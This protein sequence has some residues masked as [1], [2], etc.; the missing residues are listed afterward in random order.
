[1]GR[2]ALKLLAILAL[3]TV[4]WLI[5]WH[6]LAADERKTEEVTIYRDDFGIPNIF[7]ASEEGVAYG[8]GYA[9]A[10]D[11]L[12]EIFKQYRRAEGTMA[13]AFG[14]SFLHDD[15][16][17][18]LW[19]H[20]AVAEANYPKLSARSRVLIEAYQ[21]GIKQYM[22]E[23]PEEVPAWAPKL[24]PWQI[25]ALGRF[26]IWGWPEGD[27]SGDLQRAG[28]QPDPIAAR[29]SNQWVIAPGRTADGVPL[30]LVDPHLGWYGQFR[31]YEARLYG[32]ALQTAGMTIPGLPLSVLGHNRYCSVA[33]TTGGPD[34]ADVYEE[35]LNPENP[36]QYRYDGQWRDMTVRT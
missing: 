34:A 5:P 20:R 29:G 16:R 8:L 35:E 19:Q 31:F 22:E 26:I 28:I 7:A 13:E 1:M 36:R 24:E 10:E 3:L 2:P 32:G 15:Y 33:M 4:G 9:Q 11:R 18:R 27:A 25:I 12:E 6:S 23:H 14:P 17:Q 21:S 30:A